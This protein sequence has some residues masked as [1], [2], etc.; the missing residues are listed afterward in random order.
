[1]RCASCGTENSSDRRFCAEC[2]CALP[3]PCRKCGFPNQAS[4]KFCGGCGAALAT[5][6]SGPDL[7]SRAIDALSAVG[8][9]RQVTVL[10][11]DLSGFT[12]LS[13]VL[14]PEETHHLLNS[15]FELIDDIVVNY[16]GT[17]DK[18][19]G[20]CVMAVFGAPT[21]HTDDPERAVR[22]AL[23]IHSAIQRL[24]DKVG[25]SLK[26]HLGLASGQVVASKTG[27]RERQE[28]TVT[29]DSVNLAS[30][31]TAMAGPG[32]TFVS[33]A[34][35]GSLLDRFE[36]EGVGAISVKGFEKPVLVWRVRGLRSSDSQRIHRRLVGRHGEMAQFNGVIAGCREAGTGLAL[37]VRGEAGIGKT[38]LVEEFQRIAASKHF[39]CH[40]GRVLDFGVGKGQDAIRAIVRSCL[41]CSGQGEKAARTAAERLLSEDLLKPDQLVY[42]NDLLDLPQPTELRALYD[43]MDNSARNVG[44]RK[45][46]AQ[47]LRGL[48]VRRPQMITIEDLHWAD[49]ITLA[50]AAELTGL[51]A[52]CP[53]V[54]VMTSRTEGDQ[55]DLVWRSRTRAVPLITIDLGPLREQDALALA[56]EFSEVRLCPRVCEE[57]RR[58]PAVS[59]AAPAQRRRRRS[60]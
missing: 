18:H 41:G 38:R 21:A 24:S 45:T 32:E 46:V 3:V 31:L 5:T 10:F 26:V 55:L 1:M 33:N 9:R 49:A 14:D 43:A 48:S 50:H 53:F 36:G 44:K 52:F 19:I 60:G 51:T 28:Y 12:R 40:V 7:R 59:G 47:L 22:A 6:P 23:D 56:G 58:A 11:A 34:V 25:R 15:Y 20:D 39:A 13:S 35:Y 17:I 27:S 16:G 4:V 8:D 42:L 54:L 30:R 29:G 2:G 57:I 37:Y